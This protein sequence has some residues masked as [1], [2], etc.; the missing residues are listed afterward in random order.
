MEI[1]DA[2]ALV[3]ET[4]AA[5]G[6]PERAVAQ[7][8]YMK[9]ALPFHGVTN[10]HV[11]VLLRDLLPVL[12][13]A[14]RDVWERTVRGLWDGATHREE[15]YVALALAQHRP[16]WQWQ[17]ARALTLYE[18]LIRTGAWWDL[19]DEIAGHLVGPIL[20]QHRAAVTPVMDAW[21]TSDDLW[22]RR[23]AIISQL[24]HRDRTDTGLL[25]RAIDANAVDSH[26]GRNFF[27]RKAIG[28]ALRA[29]ARTDPQ[30]VR[31]FL[32][33]RGERLSP[34]SHREA[35]KHLPEPAQA[36]GSGSLIPSRSAT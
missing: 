11:K 33:D 25:A 36:W 18:Y 32:T 21:A 17:D 2:V 5:A 23:V 6:D 8:A 26:V 7:Q 30:W 12:G 9:S 4:L 34:L 31:A 22:L 27:I 14:D 16:A 28:W 3:R 19:V 15:R 1:D 20:H 10:P 29:H 24:K 13:S 35:A